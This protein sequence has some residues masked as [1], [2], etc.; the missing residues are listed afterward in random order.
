[1]YLN[2]E[3]PDCV[4]VSFS[5]LIKML[6]TVGTVVAWGVCHIQPFSNLHTVTQPLERGRWVHALGFQTKK[7]AFL[8][9]TDQA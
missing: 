6:H 4:P 1:M 3:I 7:K 9:Y 5:V 2:T 8:T